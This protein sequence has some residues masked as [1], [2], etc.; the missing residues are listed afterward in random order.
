MSKK[1]Y[2]N[3]LMSKKKITSRNNFL[4]IIKIKDKRV[5]SFADKKCILITLKYIKLY[6]LKY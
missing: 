4:Y 6:I 5:W 1:Y 2:S 3:F